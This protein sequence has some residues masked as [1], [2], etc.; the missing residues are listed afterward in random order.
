MPPVRPFVGLHFDPA[1]AGPLASLTAPP[2]D[3]IT[4]PERERLHRASPFN[5]V[6]LILGREQPGDDDR[7]NKY[8]RGA[9]LLRD[10]ID[11]GVLRPAPG[12]RVYPYEM[13]FAG[14]DGVRA[15]RGVVAEMD[16][17]PFGP[18]VLPHE[19]ILAAPLEDRLRLL[20]TVPAN[21]SP[22]YALV[23]GPV[24]SVGDFL[25]AASASP[26]AMEVPDEA[27]VRHRMWMVGDGF[28]D[29]T[30]ALSRG[31]VMIADGHHRYTVALRYREEMRRRVGPGP[32]DRML[33][34]LVDAADEDP[35]VLPIHR[36]TRGAVPGGTPGRRVGDLAEI[37]RTIRDEDVTYGEVRRRRGRLEHLVRTLSGDPPT[38]C[39]LHA[40]VL[41]SVPDADLAYV[42]EAAQA[43]AAVRTGR[44][45]AAFL[46][47]PTRVD[48]VWRVAAEGTTLPQKSTY[49]WPKPR[50]GLVIRPLAPPT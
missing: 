15:V 19:R 11:A 16:L 39:A 4:E 25:D 28:E 13:S 6:R 37:L 42:P 24:P 38:V 7:S 47:P 45:A 40:E 44:A 36:T 46:L 26:P 9:S 23:A 31:P 30:E 48:R 33:V 32:W 18:T 21:L 29:A 27:G 41:A 1:V 20:R 3:A 8:R 34:L 5:V 17:E 12:P 49:F 10:W 2:Y 14:A 43:E 35:P 50:T 22:V